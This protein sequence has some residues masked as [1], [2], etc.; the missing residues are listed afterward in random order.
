MQGNMT[1]QWQYDLA[2]NNFN[3]VPDL[4]IPV[5]LAISDE[6]TGQIDFGGGTVRTLFGP[7]HI[8]AGL[9]QALGLGSTN[10]TAS[11]NGGSAQGNNG[12]WNATWLTFSEELQ[13]P[14]WAEARWIAF[15]A[16]AM[17]DPYSYGPLDLQNDLIHRT[18][19]VWGMRID[20]GG[21][22]NYLRGTISS[23][24]VTDVPEPS[25]Q[26]L[27]GSGLLCLV[28]LARAHSS[29]SSMTMWKSRLVRR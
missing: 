26:I 2:T 8:D 10:F 14:S 29:G 5:T 28:L 16:S 27:L 24:S 13:G 15:D 6:T 7:V 21:L 9:F 22:Q 3:S 11:Y 1:L 4:T 23:I 20:G 25:T 12:I 18:G 19:E 17:A